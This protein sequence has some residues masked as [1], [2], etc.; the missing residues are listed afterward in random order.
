MKRKKENENKQPFEQTEMDRNRVKMKE[1]KIEMIKR[2]C[3]QS[4]RIILVTEV[5]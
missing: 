3:K 5:H 2:L 4:N 1:K